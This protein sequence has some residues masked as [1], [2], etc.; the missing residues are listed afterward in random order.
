[1][2]TKSAAAKVVPS[3]SVAKTS[4]ASTIAQ[5][6]IS[7][8]SR[9]LSE[10][11]TRKATPPLLPPSSSTPSA[12]PALQ[13][14]KSIPP[15]P[16]VVL[17]GISMNPTSKPT[18]TQPTAWKS[19]SDQASS[20]QRQQYNAGVGAGAGAGGTGQTAGKNYRKLARRWVF[21]FSLVWADGRWRRGS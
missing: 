18:A 4:M 21:F 1:K 19:V 10:L 20:T 6:K 2:K 9:I 11:A 16:K 7:S 8:S 15:P 12:A 13:T 14:T 5:S 3:G 17:P